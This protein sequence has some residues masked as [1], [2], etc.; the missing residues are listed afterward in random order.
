MSDTRTTAEKLQAEADTEQ[1][2]KTES[3]LAYLRGKADQ[4][5]QDE[6]GQTRS[7]VSIVRCTVE[8]LVMVIRGGDLSISN[9]VKQLVLLGLGELLQVLQEG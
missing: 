2:V 6:S 9:T 4:L 1:R 8:S 7:T 5:K 3:A